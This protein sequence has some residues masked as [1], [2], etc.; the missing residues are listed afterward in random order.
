MP[1]P[2]CWLAQFAPGERCEGRM[3][4]VHLVEQ[5]RLVKE[6]HADLCPDPR[7][8]E[9]GCRRHHGM[10]DHYRPGIRVPRSAVPRVLEE[11]L[12]AIGLGWA[13]DRDRRYCDQ[14]AA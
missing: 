4:R 5:Q 7:T 12:E 3:D 6:G 14:R 10:F 13:L 9:F 1:R 11:L 8:W 2:A